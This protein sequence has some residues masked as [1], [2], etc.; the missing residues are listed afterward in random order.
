MC[1]KKM[2]Y[3]LRGG[4]IG[5]AIAL[6]Y[7]IRTL[8]IGKSDNLVLWFLSLGLDLVVTFIIGALIGQVVG[9]IINKRKKKNIVK[10]KAV[11]KAR[12]RK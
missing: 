12:K 11:K 9:Y 3:W 10:K 5:V 8:I 6:I 2:K 1:W 7:D 4:L